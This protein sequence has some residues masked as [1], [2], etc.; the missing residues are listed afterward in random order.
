MV[1]VVMHMW[2]HMCSPVGMSVY[3]GVHSWIT[4]NMSV[5]FLSG[6]AE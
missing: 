4:V 2:M 1:F 5:T 6:A 3:M